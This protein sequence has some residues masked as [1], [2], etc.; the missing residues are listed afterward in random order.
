MWAEMMAQL[1]R[2]K[3]T[4]KWFVDAQHANEWPRDA[5][6]SQSPGNG[7]LLGLN[8]PHGLVLKRVIDSDTR[9]HGLGSDD[10]VGEAGTAQPCEGAVNEWSDA[11]ESGADRASE[12]APVSAPVSTGLLR[13][14]AAPPSSSVHCRNKQPSWTCLRKNSLFTC[15]FLLLLLSIYNN[16]RRPRDTQVC[17][18]TVYR[19]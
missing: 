16:E 5:M 3:S 6:Q 17:Y 14:R 12:P 19:V 18:K 9:G 2:R 13:P 15:H 8:V 7:W 1:C 10:F 11:E 4:L